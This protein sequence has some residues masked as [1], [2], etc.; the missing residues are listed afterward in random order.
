MIFVKYKRKYYYSYFVKFFGTKA[1][2]VFFGHGWAIIV[3]WRQLY[4][5]AHTQHVD[6]TGIID[7]LASTRFRPCLVLKSENF[8]EL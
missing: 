3:T 6:T 2:V 8:L 4:T 1:E 5:F 7:V